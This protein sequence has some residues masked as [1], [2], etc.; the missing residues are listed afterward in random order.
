M[1][2]TRLGV[3]PD[4]HVPKVRARG[5]GRYPVLSTRLDTYGRKQWS[6]SAC[7]KW[8]GDTSLLDVSPAPRTPPLSGLRTVLRPK[9]MLGPC[10]KADCLI[11]DANHRQALVVARSLGRA[12]LS[13]TLAES[14][15]E[16]SLHAP[17]P[18]FYSTFSAGSTTLPSMSREPDLFAA[19]VLDLIERRPTTVVV[20]STDASIAALR[21]RRTLIEERSA[22]A[23]ASEPA[24]DLANDKART[25]ALAREVGIRTPRSVTVEAPEQ[26]LGA[27]AEVGLPAVLKP[28]RS[29][30]CAGDV[31]CRVVPRDVINVDEVAAICDEIFGAGCPSV[32]VQEFVPGRREALCVFYAHRRPW[33]EFALVVHRTSPVLGGYAVVRESIPVPDDLRPAIGLLDAADLEGFSEVEFRRDTSGRPVLMEINAR[34]SGTIELPQRAGIDFPGYLFDW[35]VGAPLVPSTGYRTGV[36]LRYLYGDIQWLLENLKQPGRPDS[37]GPSRALAVFTTDSLRP[38]GYDYMDRGDL[39]PMLVATGRSVVGGTRRLRIKARSA[40]EA[41]RLAFSGVVRA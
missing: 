41:R 12:G 25:L 29:W 21:P 1:V 31:G 11:L 20:P 24:L 15:D 35:A 33:A 27:L 28:T 30:V 22:L 34:L 5:S 13:V 36:R 9:V 26:V 3:L 19:A 14:S 39:S 10:D 4:G 18:A 17:I 40:I 16:E 32:V 38:S 6:R 8:V 7:I 2:R 37:V 23:L